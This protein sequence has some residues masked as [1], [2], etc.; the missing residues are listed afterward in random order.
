MS[1]TFRDGVVVYKGD[2]FGFFSSTQHGKKFCK[3]QL[4]KLQRKQ[5]KRAKQ[6]MLQA[7]AD[8]QFDNFAEMLQEEMNQIAEA[9]QAEHDYWQERE[10]ANYADYLK[11]LE[12]EASIYY[13]YI[14]DYY[15]SEC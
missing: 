3:K 5:N 4:R 11:E 1:H 7:Y 15:Y 2:P 8:D 10:A 14:D 13:D 12:Q 6:L 9:E